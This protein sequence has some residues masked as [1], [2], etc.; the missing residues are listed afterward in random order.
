MSNRFDGLAFPTARVRY[1]GNGY[2]A[3]MYRDSERTYRARV[4]YDHSMSGGATQAVIAAQAVLA[5][6][7]VDNN[8]DASVSDYTPVPGDLDAGAYVFVFV[9]NEYLTHTPNER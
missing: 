7:L 9:P 4:A 2:A 5:K 8:P 1:T 3:S 6:S